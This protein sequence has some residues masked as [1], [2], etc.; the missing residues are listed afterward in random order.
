M[1]I[2]K[3]RRM[4]LYKVNKGRYQSLQRKEKR[5]SR[6]LKISKE[7]IVKI[8]EPAKRGNLSI[9]KPK[10]IPS[11]QDSRIKQVIISLRVNL[12]IARLSK[13]LPTKIRSIK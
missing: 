8:T 10:S 1:R 9:K 11:L 7:M 4:K 2:T 13:D 3:K 5:N 12:L 6:L